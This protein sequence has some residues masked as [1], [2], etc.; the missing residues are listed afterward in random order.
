MDHLFVGC[1]FSMEVWSQVLAC[2]PGATPFQDSVQQG[3]VSWHRRWNMKGD[4]LI[5][6]L[7]F[8][9]TLWALWEERNGR[10]FRREVKVSNRIASFIFG[11]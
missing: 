11:E 10:I 2:L 6:W 7:I 5:W 9:A 3:I 1:P 8:L 4:G